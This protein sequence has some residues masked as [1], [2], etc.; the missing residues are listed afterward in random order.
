MP[1]P[2]G[3][4]SGTSGLPWTGLQLDLHSLLGTLCGHNPKLAD[5]PKL[6][7]EKHF[8]HIRHNREG[9][10]HSDALMAPPPATTSGA[11]AAW[12]PPQLDRS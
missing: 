11:R 8:G 1:R 6:G 12:P 9:L 3:V 4:T 7:M 5:E 10:T 2:S